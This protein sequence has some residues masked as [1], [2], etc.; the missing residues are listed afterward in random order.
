[1]TRYDDAL[2]TADY[3]ALAGFR[4]HIRRFLKVSEDALAL[5]GLEPQQHQLMLAL[6]ALGTDGALS[7]GQVADWMLLRHHSVVGLVERLE[8]KGLVVRHRDDADARRVLVRLTPA[9]EQVIE[10]LSV[11]HQEELR[12]LAPD[13]ISALEQVLE[14]GS[15]GAGV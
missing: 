9:G 12:R 3:A 4:H 6:R 14:D 13:L 10:E 15:A 8:L 5:A 1:V 11:M 7:I 2:A